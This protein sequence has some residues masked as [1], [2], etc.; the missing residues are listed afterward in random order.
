MSNSDW[1]PE[2]HPDWYRDVKDM[3]YLILGS[4][5]PPEIRRDGKPG[6]DYP[7]YYPNSTNRFW[8]IL[9]RILDPNKPLKSAKKLTENEKL[10][11][12]EERY[13][14]MCSLKVGVQNM[15]LEI[16]RRNN[17]A[18]DSDID[19]KKFQNIRSIIESHKGL[20]KILLSGSSDPSSTA[21]SFLRYLKEEW[22]DKFKDISYKDVKAKD[23][24][25]NYDFDI[26]V[27][28]RPK[29]IKCI[30]VY[31]TSTAARKVKEETLLKQFKKHLVYD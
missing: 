24:E 4:F 20:E 1:K 18:R 10:E 17:S 13:K 2:T 30:V 22:K 7:F 11:A 27:F 26:F 19:I 16:E 15:G 25:V 9:A 3:K 29:P 31:S 21:K 12:V 5:P 28:N 6:W 8:K 23:I 14:I